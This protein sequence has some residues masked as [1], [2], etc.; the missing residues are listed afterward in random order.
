MNKDEITK[1]L[2]NIILNLEN[3]LNFYKNEKSKFEKNEIN[4][5][6]EQ[7]FF[8]NETLLDTLNTDRLDVKLHNFT[9][10]Y[11]KWSS[12]KECINMTNN[13]SKFAKLLLYNRNLMQIGNF[14][15]IYESIKNFVKNE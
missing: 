7:L 10:D 3:F 12:K 9:I 14:D 4:L 5:S 6:N 8:Y 15:K 1:N 2:D 11:L 13:Q